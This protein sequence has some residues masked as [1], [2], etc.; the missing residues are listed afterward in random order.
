[1]V[2]EEESKG[3][4]PDVRRLNEKWA[5]LFRLKQGNFAFSIGQT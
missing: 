4:P 3:D 2:Q 1:M 5:S